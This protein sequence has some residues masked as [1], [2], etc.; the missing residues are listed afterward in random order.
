MQGARFYL[1]SLAMASVIA[2]LMVSVS[3]CQKKKSA[4]AESPEAATAMQAIDSAMMGGSTMMHDSTMNMTGSAGKGMM[5]D[6]MSMTQYYTCPMHPQ[7]HEAQPGK[8]PICGM[9]LV[10]HK[11]DKTDK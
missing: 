8:C 9:N 4:A 3:G 2:L 11:P 1:S 6:T 10:M 7:I 5:T